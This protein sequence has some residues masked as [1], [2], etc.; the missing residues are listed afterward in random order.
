MIW[1]PVMLITFRVRSLT[2]RQ[3]AILQELADDLEGKT[4]ASSG[5]PPTAVAD[6][7]KETSSGEPESEAGPAENETEG[8]CDSC[9]LF[10]Q[11]P[12]H[13]KLPLQLGS[14]GRGGWLRWLGRL[15]G[16]T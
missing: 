9:C 7:P 15:A 11:H 14:G 16:R 3:R 8:K 2:A 4:L 12:S 5:T 13:P 6:T 10:L 1:G